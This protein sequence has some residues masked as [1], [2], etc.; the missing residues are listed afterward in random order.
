MA[1]T[2]VAVAISAIAFIVCTTDGIKMIFDDAL[3]MGLCNIAIGVCDLLLCVGFI[4]RLV[5]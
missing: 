4:M 5:G 1:L 2:I 3:G